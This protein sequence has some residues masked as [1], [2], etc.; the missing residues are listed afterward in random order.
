MGTGNRHDGPDGTSTKEVVFWLVL[1]LMW[2][3]MLWDVLT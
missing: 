2:G 3:F 1:A